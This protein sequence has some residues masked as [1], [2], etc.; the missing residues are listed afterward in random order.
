MGFIGFVT[1]AITLLACSSGDFNSGE[2]V[3][4]TFTN[5]TGWPDG[6][7][8]MLGLL[9]SFF[10]LTGFE[11]VSHMIEEMPQPSKNAPKVM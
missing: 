8:F 10:G 9:Q 6:M 7:A 1:V 11:A 4:T 3:F 5:E 2:E